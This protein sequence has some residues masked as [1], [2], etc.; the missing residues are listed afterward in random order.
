MKIEHKITI[1]DIKQGIKGITNEFTF[2]LISNPGRIFPTR[3]SLWFAS[4]KPNFEIY[5]IYRKTRNDE[6]FG[7]YG[8]YIDERGIEDEI[9][10]HCDEIK[11]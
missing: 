9:I 11:L 2:K 7:L 8:V 1:K 5:Y 10:V 4:K 3:K 6:L